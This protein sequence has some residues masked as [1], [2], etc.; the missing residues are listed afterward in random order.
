L[1]ALASIGEAGVDEVG[2]GVVREGA[3]AMAVVCVC[4]KGGG[5]GMRGE[6]ADVL[7][8]LEVLSFL[9]LLVKEYKH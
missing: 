9:A 1:V 6:S 8:P 2:G 4:V 7:L 3:G 5:V